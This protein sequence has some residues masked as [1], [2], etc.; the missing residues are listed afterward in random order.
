MCWC[1]SG[2]RTVSRSLLCH[3]AEPL[4]GISALTQ[5]PPP[6]TNASTG[7]GC[8][9]WGVARLQDFSS[10]SWVA[11]FFKAT[12]R[13]YTMEDFDYSSWN[14]YLS[15]YMGLQVCS[16]PFSS[17]LPEPCIVEAQASCDTYPT[18]PGLVGH[19]LD[20]LRAQQRRGDRAGRDQRGAPGGGLLLPAR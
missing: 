16:P 7:F 2:R 5:G 15:L 13:N 20:G 3:V 1:C 8:M 18:P 12:G 9:W 4:H 6:P 19:P 11:Q 14:Y 10:R 17:A